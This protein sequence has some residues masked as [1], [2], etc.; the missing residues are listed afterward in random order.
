MQHCLSGKPGNK[1]NMSGDRDQKVLAKA[2]QWVP[3][4]AANNHVGKGRG[5][6]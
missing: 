2:H 6:C 5:C 3:L 1:L 4:E